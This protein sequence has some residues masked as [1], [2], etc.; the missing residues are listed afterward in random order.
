MSTN[1]VVCV[2]NPRTGFD[3]LCDQCR[4]LEPSRKEIPRNFLVTIERRRRS[5]G[6]LE[7]HSFARRNC[8]QSLA[9][10]SAEYKYGF[11][12]LLKIEPLVDTKGAV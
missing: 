2:V 4:A 5:D 3:L 10:K 11:Q 1:C 7:T 6:K 9:R 12:R 8:T